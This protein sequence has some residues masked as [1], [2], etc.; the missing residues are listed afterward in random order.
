MLLDRLL[1]ISS[2][3]A[4]FPPQAPISATSRAAVAIVLRVAA[5]A[6]AAAA[7]DHAA[8]PHEFHSFRAWFPQVCPAWDGS[9]FHSPLP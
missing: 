2:S 4:F 5:T 6:D 8:F 3:S 9:A 7:I 1:A